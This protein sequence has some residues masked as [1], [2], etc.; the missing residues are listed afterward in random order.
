M[1][2][3][4]ISD[5]IFMYNL[6]MKVLNTTSFN[7]HIKLASILMVA[8]WNSFFVF[9]FSQVISVGFRY[10]GDEFFLTA[11]LCVVHL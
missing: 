8:S 11:F 9:L 4:E 6:H 2:I 5:I 10:I 1:V 7:V 3:K